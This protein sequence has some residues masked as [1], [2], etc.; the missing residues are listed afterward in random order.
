MGLSLM[1]IACAA[2]VLVILSSFARDSLAPTPS[3]PAAPSL[4]EA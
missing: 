4:H 3:S 1:R 2:L